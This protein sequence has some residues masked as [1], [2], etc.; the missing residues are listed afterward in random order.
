ME[1]KTLNKEVLKGLKVMYQSELNHLQGRLQ[2]VKQLLRSMDNAASS[3]L[4]K[5]DEDLYSKKV[6]MTATND[7]AADPGSLYLPAMTTDELPLPAVRKRGRKAGIKV[8][9]YR[10]NA[11]DDY[12]IAIL[13]GT[14]RF[15][16]RFEL[17]ERMQSCELNEWKTV[18]EHDRYNKLS[19]ILHKLSNRRGLIRKFRIKNQKGYA[20][21]LYHNFTDS[22]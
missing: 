15:M 8:G 11:I 22:N 13:N 6:I 20:Y 3:N 21:G 9:G 10:L 12:I 18:P 1:T 4:Q 5:V 2:M 19:R 17:D 7:L 14:S 16:L